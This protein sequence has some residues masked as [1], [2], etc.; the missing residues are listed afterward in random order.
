MTLLQMSL[1]GSALILAVVLVR[2]LALHK[3]PKRFFLALWGVVM[4]RLLVPVSLP[5]AFSVYSLVSR[6]NSAVPVQAVSRPVPG[7]PVG[8]PTVAELPAATPGVDIWAVIWLV[9]MVICTLFFGLAWLKCRREFR[10]SLPV[11]NPYAE[12]WLREHQLRR[13]VFIRQ[14]DKISAPLTYG[15]CRPVILMPKATDWADTQT[16]NYVLAH[17]LVHIR[18]FDALYKLVLLAALCVHW[19][20]PLVWG[21][22]VLANRDIELSCDEAVLRQFGVDSKSGYAMALIRMEER[23]SGFAPLGS[24]FSKNAIEERIT[25]IMKTR[26]K[27]IIALVIS[28][29]LVGGTIGVFA[30]SASAEAQTTKENFSDVEW[31]TAEEYAAWLEN[32]EKELHS[33]IGSRGWTQSTGWFT[34]TQELVDETI[35]VYEQTLED[36]RGG[37]RVSKPVAAEDGEGYETMVMVGYNPLD[38][39]TVEK[40]ETTMATDEEHRQKL[41]K[42]YEKFGLSYDSSSDTMFYHGQTVRYFTDSVMLGDGVITTYQHQDENGDVSLCTI[43]EATYNPDGS[44]DPMGRL[45]GIRKLTAEDLEAL[46]YAE[47]EISAE[48]A[49]AEKILVPYTPFGLTSLTDPYGRLTM[50]WQGKPVRSLFDPERQVWVANSMGEGGLGQDAVDVEAVYENGQLT[51]LREYDRDVEFLEAGIVE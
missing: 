8:V 48:A 26:K 33:A 19:F 28:I 20:N 27:S 7:A 40:D 24:H 37:L 32:E 1:S 14:S 42:E 39:Y 41:L 3:L 46:Q 16:L 38:S 2:A 31:W 12:D 6:T 23:K 5:S 18:R 50:N 49:E 45:T 4:V 17:E 47:E 51:G 29:A 13:L 44:M 11:S 10:E 36:I 35:A 9:G 43:R 25:A 34:W 30:T 15:V 22:A 21:M